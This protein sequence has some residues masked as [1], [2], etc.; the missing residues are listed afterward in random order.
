MVVLGKQGDG[1]KM[2]RTITILLVILLFAVLAAIRFFQEQLFYDPLLDFFKY[3]Y[4]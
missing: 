2:K 3:E 4:K 1:K